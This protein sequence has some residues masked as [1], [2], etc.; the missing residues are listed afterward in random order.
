MQQNDNTQKSFF[1]RTFQDH[2]ASVGESYF[3]HMGFALNVAATL[4]VAALAA[5]IHALIPRF[6]VTTASSL[7]IKL[8]KIVQ[9]R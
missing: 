7:I 9:P 6:C 3:E 1:Y 8:H 4:F 2:P 5:F